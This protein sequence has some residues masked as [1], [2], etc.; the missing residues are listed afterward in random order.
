MVFLSGSVIIFVGLLSTGF[1]DRVLK[2]REWTGI[3]FVIAGLAIVGV[4]DFISK[5]TNADNHGRNDIITGKKCLSI[6]FGRPVSKAKCI[7]VE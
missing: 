1:L 6:A 5:D 4:A 2:N 3:F 7:Y